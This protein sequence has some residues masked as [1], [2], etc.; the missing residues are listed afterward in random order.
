MDWIVDLF[1]FRNNNHLI[2][3]LTTFPL[4]IL[5]IVAFVVSKKEKKCSFVLPF[6]MLILTYAS[7]AAK[8]VQVVLIQQVESE[9]FSTDCIWYNSFLAVCYLILSIVGICYRVKK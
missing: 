6:A 3:F 7:I 4:L 2:Y 5:L 8:A 1:T 9:V